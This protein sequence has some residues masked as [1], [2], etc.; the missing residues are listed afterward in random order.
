MPVIHRLVW[1]FTVTSLI[2]MSSNEDKQCRLEV[3]G[4]EGI[5]QPGDVI[6]GAVLPVRVAD[7][8]QQLSFTECPPRTTCTMIHFGYFQQLQALFFA[9]EEIN[10]NEDILPNITLGFHWYDS[11]EVISV[12]MAA[13]LQVLSGDKTDI[14][15]Y[16]C[17]HSA[18]LSG[19]IGSSSSSLSI[20]VGHILGLYRYPQVSYYSTSSLLSDRRKFPSFF[21]TVPSDAFQSKGLAKLVL[22]YNWRWIGLLGVDNDYGQQGIQL[23]T[24]EIIRAG[25]CVDFTENILTSRQDRNAAHIVKVMKKST[26]RVVIVFAAGLDLVPI[27]TEMR[28]ENVKDKIFV[29]SEGWSVTSQQ[30]MGS[31][32]NLLFGT[33]GLAFYNGLI[34]GFQEFLNKIHPNMNVG[35]NLVKTFW[36]EAFNCTFFTEKGLERKL[37][38]GEERLAAI[39]N[40]YNDVSNLRISYNIYTAVHTLAKALDDLTQCSE[41][42]G[43]F[44]QGRCAQIQ[45]LSP[46]QILHYMKRVRVLLS[47]ERELYFDE[48]GDPPA[49]YDIVNW[50]LS[51]NTTI[52]HVK[53]GSY[54]TT[55]SDR[56]LFTI[57]S[58]LL[59]WATKDNQVPTSACT[60]SCPPGFRQ[61]SITGQPVCCFQCFPCPQ[62]EISNQTDSSSCLKCPWNEC[63]NLEKTRCLRKRIDF[64]SFDDPLGATLTGTSIASSLIPKFILRLFIQY[65]STPVVKANNYV[66]SCL[67]LA[68]LSLCFLSSLAFI[69]YPHS[70]KCL[71]RQ[72]AFGLVFTI[73]VSCILAK[74]IMVV[75][76]FMATRP[77]SV[78]RKWTNPRV[79]YTIIF[80][81]SLL[82]FILCISWL[83]LAPP[84]PQYNIESQPTLIIVECN[85]GSLIAF[86]TMLG[87]LFLL[88]FISFI[89]AFLARRLPDSFNEAQFITF[90]MLAFLSVWISYIPASLSAQGK[91]T[92]A[93]EIFAIL[94]SS[95]ALV[96]CMF[97]PKCFII[98]FRPDMNSKEYLMRRRH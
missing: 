70:D 71:L 35:G 94:S 33:V 74:T 3:L 45:N 98:L 11:C 9:V 25:A 60:E 37:C 51:S 85:E 81:C 42:K 13:T 73:C 84:F 64:L 93:M 69:G 82:Q 8:F 61:A 18:P 31:F 54:D 29:A 4:L 14:P 46:W 83:S 30:K 34:P 41:G 96:L 47:N 86:W 22:H 27:L 2:P 72:T 67:L 59:L 23:V 48:N 63:P 5:Q 80:T 40:S 15:N 43:P 49:V 50:Q 68:S 26:A 39:K 52:R 1:I 76:A 77:G 90:S 53:V 32:S 57:N 79:S 16:R 36:E 62:G 21:R 65:K 7:H 78:V 97:F 92:V 28:K 91:Y 6:I 56:Q 89:V 75:F 87:Y 66:L 95:W 17:L 20:A 44:L 24:Q 10:K 58:S 38:T 88:A 55:A 12:N 19:F